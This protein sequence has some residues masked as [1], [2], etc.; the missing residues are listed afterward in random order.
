ML[1]DL[2]FHV[3]EH[4]FTILE[5]QNCLSELDLRFC[6]F[7]GDDIIK[8]FKLFNTGLED[9]YDLDKWNAYE[10]K[11]PSS[12]IGMYQFWCQKI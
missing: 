11:N 8:H 3:K 4:R 12:F 7:E 9:I 10:G 2:L 1:R 5:I 6:G